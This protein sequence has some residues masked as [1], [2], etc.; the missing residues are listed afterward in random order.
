M[1]KKTKEATKKEL[2]VYLSLKQVAETDGGKV[3]LASHMQDVNNIVSQLGSQYE[4]LTHTQMIALCA[5]L[6]SL[7]NIVRALKNAEKNA[8]LLEEEMQK[9]ENE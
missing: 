2:D 1:D 8:E 5:Q 3:L 9:Y 4:T 6:G 7:L